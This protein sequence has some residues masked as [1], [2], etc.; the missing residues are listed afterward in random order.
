MGD[1]PKDTYLANERAVVQTLIELTPVCG[2]SF[3]VC[4]LRNCTSPFPSPLEARP[5]FGPRDQVLGWQ[6][7]LAQGPRGSGQNLPHQLAQAC[8]H[9]QPPGPAAGWNR[10]WQAGP[11]HGAQAAALQPVPPAGSPCC[12]VA[13]VVGLPWLP[14]PTRKPAAAALLLEMLVAP[15]AAVLPGPESQPPF[16]SPP[17]SVIPPVGRK[18]SNSQQGGDTFSSNPLSSDPI[19]S[20]CKLWSVARWG[21][22]E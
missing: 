3:N 15:P 17:A 20:L 8:S 21:T 19:Q 18:C 12:A 9:K 7:H 10:G 13:V 14:G 5:G 6:P 16:L 22:L 4:C 1:L 11:G 2:L